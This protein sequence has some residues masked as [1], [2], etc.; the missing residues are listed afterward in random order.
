MTW[1]LGYRR[2]DYLKPSPSYRG[3][4]KKAFNCGY[5][6]GFYDVPRARLDHLGCGYPAAEPG[7]YSV[8]YGWGQ[9]DG[10][11]SVSAAYS[12][13]DYIVNESVEIAEK[14]P[15]PAMTLGRGV[16]LI[17]DGIDPQRW[18]ALGELYNLEIST[19]AGLDFGKAEMTILSLSDYH[20]EIPGP[21]DLRIIDE[22]HKI[23]AEPV[24]PVRGRWTPEPNRKRF[25]RSQRRRK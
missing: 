20:G 16:L 14:D 5:Y 12:M 24:E 25:K 4:E 8:A 10:G 11:H 21:C 13:R 3:L 22:C 1:R 18:H 2:R 15:A 9:H 17:G 7:V 23:K 6:D 19:L